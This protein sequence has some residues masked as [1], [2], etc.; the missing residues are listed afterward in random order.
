LPGHAA[1]LPPVSFAAP[2]G[3][4]LVTI[5]GIHVGGGDNQTKKFLLYC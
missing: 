1:T 2:H 5:V 3:G 4:S